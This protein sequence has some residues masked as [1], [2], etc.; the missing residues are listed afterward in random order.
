MK[1]FL[2]IADP[3]G[4]IVDAIGET[5]TVLLPYI[6]AAVAVLLV[7]AAVIITVVVVRKKKKTDTSAEVI[8]YTDPDIVPCCGAVP[9]EEDV[10]AEAE[11]DTPDEEN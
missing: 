1:I 10:P 9:E 11:T 6:I 2:D 8:D 5:T 7:I 3:T 4:Q